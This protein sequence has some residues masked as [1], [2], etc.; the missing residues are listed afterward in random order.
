MKKPYSPPPSFA[1][2]E[3]NSQPLDDAI[4]NPPLSMRLY[5]LLI[6]KNY[7]TNDPIIPNKTQEL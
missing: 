2:L 4:Q 6:K 1:T 7:L 5:L 3:L